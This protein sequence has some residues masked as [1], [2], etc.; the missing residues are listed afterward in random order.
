VL[1]CGA[2]P[3]FIDVDPETYN[4]DPSLIPEEVRKKTR[5]IIPVHTFGQP[6]DMAP[7][8]EYAKKFHLRVIEDAACALGAK[9]NG[10]YAGTIG[11]V[12]CFSLHARKGFT[13]GEGGL[14]VTNNDEIASQARSLMN[15]GIS[16][17]WDREGQIMI[18]VFEKLGFNY[19][20]SDITAAIACAQLSRFDEVLEWRR[21]LGHL[22]T[23]AIGDI[24]YLVPPKVEGEDHIYQSYVPVT[25]F[26]NRNKLILNLR[27]QGI[28]AQIGTYASQMQPV[29]NSKDKCPVSMQ[30][31]DQAI[32]LPIYS[33][34]IGPEIEEMASKIQRT[35]KGMT[36]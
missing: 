33:K 11:D 16:S 35:I 9:Y 7:I 17:A 6:A 32:A 18:P 36:T 5:V 27:A 20:M 28:Q 30:L 21:V 2:V 29:Y 8:M 34:L 22:W 13:S 10:Q 26:I 4:L 24:Q 15:F 23:Q 14:L 12:G 31:F 19:K 25:K 3:R 1:Y